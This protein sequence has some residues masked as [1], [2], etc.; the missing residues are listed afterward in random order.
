MNEDLYKFFYNFPDE[1]H[2]R[3][4]CKFRQGKEA[5]YFLRTNGRFNCGK[6]KSLV[7]DV[8][9][10]LKHENKVKEDWPKGDNCP[11]LLGYIIENQ[12]RLKNLRLKYQ[13][14]MNGLEETGFL[15]E[16][17]VRDDELYLVAEWGSKNI[18]PVLEIKKLD[19][20]VEKHG[21]I[22]QVSWGIGISEKEMIIY[23][24]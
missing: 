22:F 24:A 19:I 20:S 3:T 21:L 18:C 23:F 13:E 4:V 2:I 14:A 6:S 11:G 17:V 9:D 5:C 7:R 8:M 1:K 16:L 15:K 12:S 10:E